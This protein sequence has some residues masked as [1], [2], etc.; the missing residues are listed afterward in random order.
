[1]EWMAIQGARQNEIKLFGGGGVRSFVS[2]PQCVEQLG[3]F[4]KTLFFPFGCKMGMSRML[5][6]LILVFVKNKLN[7]GQSLLP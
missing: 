6:H 5:F 4:W 2:Y 3:Q 7:V 1:M